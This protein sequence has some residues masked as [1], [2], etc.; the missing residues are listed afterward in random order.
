[1]FEDHRLADLL[2]VD[3]GLGAGQRLQGDHH[4]TETGGK[5][6]QSAAHK[7]SMLTR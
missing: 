7:L 1:M 3:V 4:C 6:R 5:A 2:A